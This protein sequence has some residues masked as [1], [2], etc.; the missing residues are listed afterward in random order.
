[1]N[2]GGDSW[3]AAPAE[4]AASTIDSLK[5][6]KMLKGYATSDMSKVG[7]EDKNGIPSVHYQ[8]TMDPGVGSML[9]LPTAT[10]TIDTWLAKDGGFPVSALIV[11]EGKNEAGEAGTFSV[12]VDVTGVNDPNLKIEAP[13]NVQEMPG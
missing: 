7:E 12:S 1:M 2:L 3:M 8:S 10:W 6:D 4:D 9:G 5:P 11:A 13:A